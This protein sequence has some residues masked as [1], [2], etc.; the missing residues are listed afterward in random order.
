M[1]KLVRS[2]DIV[3]RSFEV[4][5]NRAPDD[6]AYRLYGITKWANENDYDLVIHLHLNDNPGAE[7]QSGYAVYIPD[8]QFGNAAA[9][10]PLGE[11]IMNEFERYNTSSTLPIETYGLVEDQDL[12]ALGAFNTADFASVLIEY[13][14]IYESKIRYAGARDS[15]LT[16]MAWQT[17]RGVEAYVGGVLP[18]NDT[19][20]LPYLWTATPLKNGDSSP[21]IYALQVALH[22]LGFYPPAGEL[23]VGCPVS[24]YAGSCTTSAVKAFQK[25]KG[26][27]QTGSLGPRTI[28]ALKKAGF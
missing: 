6:V 17:Y 10:R 5:H 1:A 23:L 26:L 28:A 13:A 15:V 22:K 3:D 21:Q 8:V 9:S 12:I 24:G 4:A 27:E 14:Y 2:D 20:A 18:K 7:F 19:L 16:D 25:S 11:K